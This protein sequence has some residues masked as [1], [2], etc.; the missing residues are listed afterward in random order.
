MRAISILLALAVSLVFVGTLSAA[1]QACPATKSE[2]H[3]HAMMGP[4]NMLKGLNL[5][6]DQKAKVKELWKEYEPKFKAAA[7]TVLTADQKKVRDAAITAAKESGKKGPPHFDLKLTDEQ[8]AKMKEVMTPLH[9][10]IH[11]KITALLTP[12][13]QE[14]LKAKMAEHKAKMDKAE[15]K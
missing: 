9:K 5:T 12:E 4:W 1:D 7:N 2:G 15:S 10:E 11:E 3:E 6:D 14:Q 13:Q 8:K